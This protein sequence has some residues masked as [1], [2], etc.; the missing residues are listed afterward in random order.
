MDVLCIFPLSNN[1]E[2]LKDII[3]CFIREIAVNLAPPCTNVHIITPNPDYQYVGVGDIVPI[4]KPKGQ[5]IIDAIKSSSPQ[6]DY[7]LMCDGSGAIPYKYTIDIFQALISDPKIHC[8]MIERI[9]QNKAISKERFLIEKFEV[10]SLKKFFGYAED[11]PDGQGGLWGFYRREIEK[12]GIKN[13]INL[14]AKEYDIELDLLS[15]VLEKNFGFLFVPITLP[16]REIISAFTYE[17]NIRKMIFLLDKHPMLSNKLKSFL[18][19]YL[20]QAKQEI[21]TLD[22]NGKI[23]WEKYKKDVLTLLK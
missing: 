7:V 15:E 2:K 16:K 1:Y 11:I 12:N 23:I 21:D 14:T 5:F 18:D 8:A 19:E 10:F 4:S 3:D 6:I 13:K 17:N 22:E 9:G 20:I